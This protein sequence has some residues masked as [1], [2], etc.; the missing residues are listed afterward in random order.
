MEDPYQLNFITKV[1]SKRIA[2]VMTIAILNF[3][4]K[5]IPYSLCTYPKVVVS[6]ADIQRK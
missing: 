1:N 2:I 6:I 4:F 3:L 5:R